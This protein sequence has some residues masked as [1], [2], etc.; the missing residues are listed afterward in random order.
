M[1]IG[2]HENID[3]EDLHVEEVVNKREEEVGT[4]EINSVVLNNDVKNDNEKVT[5]N[6]FSTQHFLPGNATIYIRSWGCSHNNVSNFIFFSFYLY[7]HIYIYSFSI[8]IY[9]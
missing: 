8:K 3:I 4:V 6:K 2:L 1:D 7:T 5:D 9:I